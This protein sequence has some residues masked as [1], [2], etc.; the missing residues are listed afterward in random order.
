MNA[1]RVPFLGRSRE[2]GSGA[3]ARLVGA[4]MRRPVLDALASAGFLLVLAIPMLR[5]QIGVT[6]FTNFPDQIDGV[7]AVKL[8]EAK[9]P[10]GT[11]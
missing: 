7:Q 4:V 5:L 10:A 2:E 6:D 11:V 1:G 3:W 9:W 8:L